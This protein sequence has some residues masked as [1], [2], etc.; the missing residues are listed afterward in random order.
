MIER[1]CNECTLCCKLLPVPQLQKPANTRCAFQRAGKGCTLHQSPRYPSHCSIW[2]CA[3]LSGADL[4][5]PDRA[6]YVVDPLIDF[7]E[8]EH[9]AA[10]RVRIDVVQ[11]WVDPRHPDAHRD[12]ALRAYLAAAALKF[13][14]AA[15]VRYDATRGITLFAPSMTNT[16]DW[17]EGASTS[18]GRDHTP[19]EIYRK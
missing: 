19:A 3:W 13:N 12:P 8:L 4:P 10:G 9:P 17:I 2:A 11:V 5:R 7:I 18:L 1:R 14:R 15:L 6:H 16:G